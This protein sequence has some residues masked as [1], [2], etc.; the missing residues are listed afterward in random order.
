[1]L[2]YKNPSL[3]SVQIYKN[4]RSDGESAQALMVGTSRQEGEGALCVEGNM[5]GGLD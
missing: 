4:V 2:W 5:G 1:M 3:V